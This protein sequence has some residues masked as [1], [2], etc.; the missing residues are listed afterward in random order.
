MRMPPFRLLSRHPPGVSVAPSAVT[1]RTRPSLTARPLR[2]QLS[3]G[4]SFSTK[5]APTGFEAI[6]VTSLCQATESCV[7]EDQF[8]VDPGHLVDLHVAGRMA[9][10][11]Q[12]T[13]VV[14]KRGV[15]VF[16]EFAEFRSNGGNVVEL[17]NVDLTADCQFAA[18]DSQPHGLH[19]VAKV[20]V[21][22]PA[23]IS[24]DDQF[25]GLI[26]GDEHRSAH[27]LEQLGKSVSMNA[28]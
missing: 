20:G 22:N 6:D 9:T 4:T 1:Y 8:V 11:R 17:P 23:V 14:L 21:Q 15:F 26:G 13:G 24:Q 2:W 28:S 19:E 16:V 12:E 5:P 7:D 27:L 10:A 18:F 25:P 3:P